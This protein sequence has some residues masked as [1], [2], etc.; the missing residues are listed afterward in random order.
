MTQVQT[1]E[2]KEAKIF[3]WFSAQFENIQ[4]KFKALRDEFQKLI[5]RAN[6]KAGGLKGLAIS[7]T[8][9][10]VQ[11]VHEY[12]KFL[13]DTSYF[14]D[15]MLENFSRQWG[16]GA[17]LLDVVLERDDDLP[18]WLIAEG[19]I[20]SFYRTVRNEYNSIRICLGE[21]FAYE[22]PPALSYASTAVSNN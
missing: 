7:A 17:D 2:K 20:I 11:D 19:E 4:K 16:G 15:A 8:V 5:S 13:Q 18:F 3:N 9:S 22:Q 10:F 21:F 1:V 6:Q 14:L 12:A